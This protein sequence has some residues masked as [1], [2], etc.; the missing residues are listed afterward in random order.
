MLP[1]IFQLHKTQAEL[2]TILCS[3]L[4]T[5]FAWV[6]SPQLISS[7]AVRFGALFTLALL[8]FPAI[9]CNLE[10][11]ALL[12]IWFS[13]FHDCLIMQWLTNLPCILLL[14]WDSSRVCNLFF[15]SFF[16]SKTIFLALLNTMRHILNVSFTSLYCYYHSTL[17]TC[18]SILRT[19]LYFMLFSTSVHLR[20]A[21]CHN[22][23]SHS[24]LDKC[25]IIYL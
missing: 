2:Q 23:D 12:Q 7:A 1:L 25:N 3:L 16:C 14:A 10:I 9:L 18:T 11:W 6:T 24:I 19:V 8:P 21:G 20:S 5:Y 22:V 13:A 15:S 4:S 17:L